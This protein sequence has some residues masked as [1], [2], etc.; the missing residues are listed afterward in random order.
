MINRNVPSVIVP[1]DSEGWGAIYDLCEDERDYL[2]FSI[3]ESHI[4]VLYSKRFFDLINEKLDVW[5]DECEEAVIND[6]VKIK[7]LIDYLSSVEFRDCIHA[8]G[9]EYENDTA[10]YYADKI[11]LMAKK[12]LRLKTPILFHF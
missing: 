1:V 4:A 7:M 3:N 9:E 6:P 10:D 2:V 11:T 8:S 12:A 5:I